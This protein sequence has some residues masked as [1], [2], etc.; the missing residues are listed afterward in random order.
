MG[1]YVPRPYFIHYNLESEGVP[2]G[3]QVCSVYRNQSK[4]PLSFF[5][6]GNG[7]AQVKFYLD[8]GIAQCVSTEYW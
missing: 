8:I 6:G 4:L 5:L 1:Q 2:Q 7:F 3:S